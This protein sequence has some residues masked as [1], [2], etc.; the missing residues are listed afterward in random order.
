VYAG[1]GRACIGLFASLALY[2]SAKPLEHCG[3]T[4]PGC[5]CAAVLSA[6]QCR[7][8]LQGS[9][10]LHHAVREGHQ[11]VVQLLLRCARIRTWS[12]QVVAVPFCAA[13]PQ[14]HYSP[15]L[16]CRNKANPNVRNFNKS[17]YASGNWIRCAWPA[18][19]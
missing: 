2:S 16:L 3:Q 13:A 1:K 8:A 14:C 5:R 10:A 6:S 11:G 15:T 7:T 4:A 9:S 18:G 17:E 12:G 19:R